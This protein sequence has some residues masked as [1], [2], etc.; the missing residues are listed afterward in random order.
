MRIIKYIFLLI[1]LAILAVYLSKKYILKSEL[2]P[3]EYRKLPYKYTSLSKT[4]NSSFSLHDS[5]IKIPKIIHRIWI[6]FNS[7]NIVVPE[8]YQKFDIKL[9]E[10]HPDY[11]FMEWDENSLDEFIKKHYPEFWPVFSSYDMKVKK[12]DAARYVLLHHF[13]GIFIQHSLLFQK[14]IDDLLY[15]SDLL[16]TEQD[17]HTNQ[18]WNGFM[19]SVPAH[20]LMK[21]MIDNL[22]RKVGGLPIHSTGPA[23]FTYYIHEFLRKRKNNNFTVLPSY[24]LLPF[25]YEEKNR[26]PFF[27]KCLRSTDGECFGLFSEA[28]SYTLWSAEWAK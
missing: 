26:E 2:I 17:Y 28:Y 4:Y 10:L 14:P 7:N 6:P 18:I 22:H 5:E 19:A 16:L 20:P 23:I 11:E 12:H 25:S 27:T 21:Y 9:K 3:L 13:G 24:Y 1:I 8:I 15:G